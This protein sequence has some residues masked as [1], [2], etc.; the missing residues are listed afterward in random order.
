MKRNNLDKISAYKRLNLQD[1]G[2]LA[3]FLINNDNQSSSAK[4]L[5]AKKLNIPIL[6]EK[7]FT[8][9]FL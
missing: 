9:R 1:D 8:E 4:N 2:N 3:D 7:E 6:T 5:A